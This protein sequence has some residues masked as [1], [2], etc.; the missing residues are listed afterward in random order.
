M[1][2]LWIIILSLSFLGICV[3]APCSEAFQV[4]VSQ[5]SSAGTGDFDANVLGFIDPFFTGLS[6]A[7]FY[8]YGV[9]NG[10][11]YNGE[12]NGGPFPVSSLSQLFF[13]DALD[14]LS[15]VVVHDNPID[16]T[17][18]STQTQWNLAG[19]SAAFVVVDDPG[20]GVTVSAGGTQFN[21]TKNWAPC[22]TDGYAIGSLDGVWA[23]F[24]QFLAL[25]TGI[26]QWAAVSSDGGSISLELEEGRRVRF[27]RIQL[28][29][30][31]IKPGSCPN[32]INVKSKGVLPAAIM[33]TDSFDVTTIDPASL[34][35]RLK[36]TEDEG[37]P[38]LR[39][40]LADVGAPFEPFIGKEDCYGD[41]VDCSCADGKL[42]LVFHFDTQEVVAALGE[43]YDEDCLVLEI[44]GALKEEYNGTPIIGEDV[45][46]MLVKGKRK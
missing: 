43:V 19:D 14:G 35:L 41:C 11:S 7:D 26:D 21:S 10:A 30:V 27:D 28:V 40:A 33:G 31:D 22:C 24:G 3:T 8:Q 12:L 6:I 23:M 15:M 4:R 44:I 9:P 39:W 32:P 16:G 1:K 25:P 37:V 42:D 17:G 5:E 38:P 18:G 46:R 34:R 29:S 20:E 13:V 45:V 2:K 36:G